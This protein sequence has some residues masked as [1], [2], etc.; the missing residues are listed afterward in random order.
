M[1]E[2]ASI[3]C[4]RHSKRE[5]KHKAKCKANKKAYCNWVKFLHDVIQMVED[6]S[7][8]STMGIATTPWM[9]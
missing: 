7:I 2:K 1:V 4:K 6:I 8:A 3:A 5:G 9:S